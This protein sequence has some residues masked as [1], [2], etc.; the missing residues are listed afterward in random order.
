MPR[1]DRRDFVALCAAI[2]GLPLPAFADAPAATVAFPDGG[3]APR[4]GQGSWHMADGRNPHE[5]VQQAMRLGITLGMTLIDTA[6]DYSAGRAEELIADVIAG[7]RDKVFLVSKL[8]PEEATED[9]I[10]RALEASL[11]RLKT[12]R[13]DLYLLHFRREADLSAVVKGFERAVDGGL[14]RRWGVSNF[15]RRDMDDLFAVPG[16]DGCATNQVLYNLPARGIETEL[17]PWCHRHRM[18]IMAYSPLGAGGKGAILAHPVLRRLA[19]ARAV[20]P[21]AIALAW[22]MRDGK[23]IA[24][25][26]A[27][28]ETHVRENAAAVSLILSEGET[29]ALDEAFPLPRAG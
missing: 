21:A 26:E 16:G 6:N 17:I 22:T 29:K 23:T 9:G 13:L 20:S 12:D 10:G 28:S 1:F 8:M 15:T 19:D 11:K 18:P 25:T 24:V 27:S 14:T 5:A 2:G 7:Q 4:L 3:R